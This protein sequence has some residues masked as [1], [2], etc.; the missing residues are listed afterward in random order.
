MTECL[1]KI[2][3]VHGLEERMNERGRLAQIH[4]HLGSARVIQ[5]LFC[6]DQQMED[7]IHAKLAANKNLAGVSCLVNPP[8]RS[9]SVKLGTG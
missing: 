6:K 5:N 3:S 8:L 2:K 4:W 7:V 9:F 1:M